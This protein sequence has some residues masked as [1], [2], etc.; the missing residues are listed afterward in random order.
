MAFLKRIG[1]WLLTNVLVIT[2]ITIVFQ[3]FNL[4]PYLAQNGINYTSLAIFCFLWGTFG[5][6]ISLFMSKRMAIWSAKVQVIKQPKNQTEQKLMNMIQKI[7]Q[8]KNLPMPE[9]GIY[10]SP[11]VNAFATGWSKNHSLVAVSTG[12]LT[13]MNDDEVEGV[14]AHEMAHIE[15]GDMVTM[16][17]LQGVMNAFV[18]FLSR[19]AAYVI[20]GLLGK[21]GKEVGRGMYS[22]IVI[23]SQ[24]VLGLLSS[25]VIYG[26]SRHREYKADYGSAT[27]VG[28]RKMIA[29]L[30]ALQRIHQPKVE[31][32][33]NYEVMKI[34]SMQGRSKRGFKDL[35]RTHPRLEDRIRALEMAPIS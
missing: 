26:F 35:F 10:N 6:L 31:G 1:L 20:A 17:L 3:V 21:D 15:N 8:I 4:E 18:M 22:L 27:A 5:S 7:A 9:V 12:L 14:M 34:S 30:K 28:K 11:E 33:K 25:L 13:K 19:V 23:V 16:T 29:A 32:M 2:L 24:I